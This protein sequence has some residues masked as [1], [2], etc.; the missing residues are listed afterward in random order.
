LHFPTEKRNDESKKVNKRTVGEGGKEGW[1]ETSHN[2][3]QR[4]AANQIKIEKREDRKFER[5]HAPQREKSG[6]VVP[7]NGVR[8]YKHEA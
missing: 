7:K 2:G 1:G 8:K 6:P 5:N 4:T 3:K